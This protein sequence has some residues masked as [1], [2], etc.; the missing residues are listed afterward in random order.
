L[1]SSH[2]IQHDAAAHRQCAAPVTLLRPADTVT[3]ID[4]SVRDP[5]HG[6]APAR[7]MDA[8]PT[9]TACGVAGF[10]PVSESPSSPPTSRGS[11][12]RQRPVSVM[13]VVRRLA[14]RSK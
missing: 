9:I 6:L 10:P 13:H 2:T 11:R 12:P 1:L 14:Q 8:R 3:G 4:A 5:H 7:P